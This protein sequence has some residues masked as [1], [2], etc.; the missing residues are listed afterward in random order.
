MLK[1][2]REGIKVNTILVISEE[3][4]T[5]EIIEGAFAVC[6]P[7]T[8]VETIQL[9]ENVRELIGELHPNLIILDLDN[10]QVNSFD[11][12]SLI[13]S[14]ST[15]PLITVSGNSDTS[16]SIKAVQRGS[17]GHLIKPVHQMELVTRARACVRRSGI[18]CK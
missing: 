2:S 6:M 14:Y 5:I 7:E 3:A 16:L 9:G 1:V 4:E 18:D 13:R 8:D 10:E 17:D 11:V 15:V 12:L